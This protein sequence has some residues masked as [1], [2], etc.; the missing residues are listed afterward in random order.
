[1]HRFKDAEQV[2]GRKNKLK[3]YVKDYPTKVIVHGYIAN[4]NQISIEPLKN[5]Y[6]SRGGVN[7]IVVDWELAALQLYDKSRAL[8]PHIAKRIGMILADLIMYILTMTTCLDNWLKIVLIFQLREA[9]HGSSAY[10]WS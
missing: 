4:R 8:V 1:M 6:L 3:N 5:A 9:R 2:V 10:T 7:L